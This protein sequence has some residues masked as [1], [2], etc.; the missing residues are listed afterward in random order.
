MYI[1]ILNIFLYYLFYKNITY[2]YIQGTIKIADFGWSIHA[3]SN[4]RLTIC[5]TLDYLSPEMV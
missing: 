4:R 1:Y 5:G 3:P 2:I